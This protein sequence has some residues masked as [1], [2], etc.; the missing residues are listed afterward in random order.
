MKRKKK[1]VSPLGV[2]EKIV[3]TAKKITSIYHFSVKYR[4]ELVDKIQISR[5]EHNGLIINAGGYTHLIAI[6]D[7]LKILQIP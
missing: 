5:K 7:A 1:I 6:H 2:I 3:K 4:G